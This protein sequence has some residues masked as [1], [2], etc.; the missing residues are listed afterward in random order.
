[1]K[2]LGIDYGKRKIGL[3]ISEGLTASPLSI[4]ES[5]GLEDALQKVRVFLAKEGVDKV[6]VGV[7]E[8]GESRNMT[9]KFINRL[10]EEIEV[11]E[12]EETLSSKLADEKMRI[13]DV[14]RSKI[15]TNDAVAAVIILEEYLDN[16]SMNREEGIS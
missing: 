8:S 9:Q 13:A 11:I 16:L 5:S 10:K 6:V 14:K 15:K 7:A 12:V 3:A 4:I 1:M 2:Y